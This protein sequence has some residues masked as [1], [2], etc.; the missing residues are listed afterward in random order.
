VNPSRA[1]T[2]SAAS[3]TA[4]QRL[5]HSYTPSTPEFCLVSRIAIRLLLVAVAVKVLRFLPESLDD[6]TV[7]PHASAAKD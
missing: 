3:T 1:W 4:R 5:A 6:A 7:D 2:S